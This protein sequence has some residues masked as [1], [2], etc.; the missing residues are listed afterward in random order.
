[1]ITKEPFNGKVADCGIS[2][3]RAEFLRKTA[4]KTVFGE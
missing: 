1:M 4:E 2:P 3:E